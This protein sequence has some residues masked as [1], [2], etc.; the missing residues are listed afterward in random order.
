MARVHTTIAVG[1]LVLGLADVLYLDL[2]VAP[3]LFRA[4]REEVT[5]SA[6]DGAE[7][8]PLLAQRRLA[9]PPDG[10]DPSGTVDHTGARPGVRAIDPELSART[11]AEPEP[12][13]SARRGDEEQ[14]ALALPSSRTA[15]AADADDDESEGDVADPD[16]LPDTLPSEPVHV[17][18]ARE[19]ATLSPR[20]RA[21]LD[22]I[23][24]WLRAEPALQATVDGHADRSGE[25]MFND[26]LSRRRAERVV[27]YF[28]AAGV[29][30]RRLSMR[31]F[32]ERRPLIRGSGIG[33]GRRNRRV[34]I[35]VSPARPGGAP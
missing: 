30:R 29:E 6:G 15:A 17:L 9:A 22:R 11:G 31:A 3:S 19:R 14:G 12:E 24:A 18:F 8:E 10:L 7:A 26:V 28:L 33:Q 23:V 32:G 4:Q 20:A 1:C 34:E 35:R 5:A 13:P 25:P 27:A 2:A 21:R 16:P